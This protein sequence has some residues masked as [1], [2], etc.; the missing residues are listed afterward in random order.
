MIINFSDKET[1]KIFNQVFSKK[2]PY[3]IQKTALRKLLWIDCSG[4]INDLI[5]PP[6]N[7][8]EK[9][10]GNYQGK[11]SIRINNQWRIVFR[12]SDDWKQYYDVEII[13]YH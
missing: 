1:E 2:F 13:D 6:S 4:S 8:L 5:V 3:N 12:P 7:H 10:S 11:W 9:L